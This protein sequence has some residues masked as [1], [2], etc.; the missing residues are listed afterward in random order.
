M[1]M[2]T[3]RPL[4]DLEHAHEFVARHIGISEDDERLMLSVIGEA[5]RRALIDG[6]VP[7]SIARSKPMALPPVPG[8]DAS[9]AG[10]SVAAA[11]GALPPVVGA[12]A[13]A[14]AVS[15][16]INKNRIDMGRTL[17]MG[18]GLSVQ[19]NWIDIRL[20]RD[21]NQDHG[22]GARLLSIWARLRRP[23]FNLGEAPPPGFQFG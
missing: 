6:I 18:W 7:R 3:A 19:V 13:G 14:H 20:L 5:S 1:L 11:A 2:P 17:V 12:A 10:A 4:A 15:S 16:R 23:G 22:I 9:A 8:A 21:D